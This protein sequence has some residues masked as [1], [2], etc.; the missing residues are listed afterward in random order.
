MSFDFLKRNLG[1]KILSL[2]LAF[3]L[4]AYVKY[5]STPYASM[6]SETKMPA[7]LVV[8]GI[9]ENLVVLDAPTLVT[10][11]VRGAP[12]K[13]A[14][15]KPSHF[16][17][18]IDAGDKKAGL[19]NISVNVSAPP[20]IKVVR[21]EPERVTIRLDPF[22]KR[23]FSAKIEPQGTIAGGYIMGKFSAQP[24]SVTVSGAQ[25][26]LAQVKEVRAVCNV[27]GADVTQV[28]RI[29]VDIVD[30]QGHIVTGLKAEPGFVRATINVHH[31]VVNATLPITA[32]LVGNPA[33]GYV[34]SRVTITPPTATIQYPQSL[35]AVPKTLKTQEVPIDG[36]NASIAREIGISAPRDVSL[37]EPQS[38]RIHVM[39][40]PAERSARKDEGPGDKE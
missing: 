26:L 18:V 5:T 1:L 34:I 32:N 35:D 13:L 2:I 19:Y 28:Q 36:A 25:S 31:E 37:M 30:D 21:V 27:D 23:L 11:T 6:S 15:L 22:E 33:K 7:N 14:S 4:W 39:I 9:P 38:V 12:D 40:V 17:A 16:R 8:E 3:T 10:L 29:A 24:E 20:E